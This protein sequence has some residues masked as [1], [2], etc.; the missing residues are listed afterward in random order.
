M[1][2]PSSK[3]TM[4]AG[5][6]AKE[7]VSPAFVERGID[8]GLED[9]RIKPQE[10][11]VEENR[12]AYRGLGEETGARKEK[13]RFHSAEFSIRGLELSY[14]FKIWNLSPVSMCVLVKED[15]DILGRLRVGDTMVVRYYPCDSS[16][17]CE[18]QKTAIRHI[19]RSD[20]GRFE[21]HYVVGLEIL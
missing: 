17:P 3:C 18:C 2:A 8:Q 13:G 16:S 11:R 19:T 12:A 5:D 6:G 20:H 14:Q 7:W 10:E 1:D 9:P 21:G 4:L 15:S